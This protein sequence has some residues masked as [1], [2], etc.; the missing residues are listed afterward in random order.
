VISL[1]TRRLKME[2]KLGRAQAP[3]TLFWR[4]S[5]NQEQEFSEN[6][7]DLEDDND[8]DGLEFLCTMCEACD[9]CE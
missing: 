9:T 7:A 4:L 6:T 3:C 2:E 1:K 8:D 5:K